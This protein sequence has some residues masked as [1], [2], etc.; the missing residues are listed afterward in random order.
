VDA[1]TGDAPISPQA[2]DYIRTLSGP[3]PGVV[4]AKS[5]KKYSTERH[6]FVIDDR[7]V[8]KRYRA[9]AWGRW[10]TP[11]WKREHEALERLRGLPV[12]QT[13]GYFRARTGPNRDA[14]Y[15][16]ECVRGESLQDSIPILTE[17][18]LPEVAR[19]VAEVHNRLV[20]AND[21][22]LHNLLRAEDGRLY[23][24]DFHRARTFH[25]RNLNY[26]LYVGK[27]L[28]HI[29][30]VSCWRD[31]KLFSAFLNLYFACPGTAQGGERATVLHA[32]RFW[33]RTYRVSPPP[34]Y[35]PT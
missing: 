32:F 9:Y 11:Y 14:I 6:V 8:V 18:V 7:Y 4:V 23:F 3:K 33:C 26:W 35:R 17:A 5:R 29:Y 10:W 13:Y 22:A 24:I 21:Y 19:L 20:I 15:A 31:A 2:F 34:K 12:P 28:C 30:K 27:D 25:S 16:R 1:K